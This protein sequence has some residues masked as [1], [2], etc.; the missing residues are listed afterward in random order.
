MRCDNVGWDSGLIRGLWN[1]SS[2]DEKLEEILQVIEY[3]Y[4]SSICMSVS[5]IYPLKGNESISY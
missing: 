3:N 2:M 4:F 1:Q 5:R